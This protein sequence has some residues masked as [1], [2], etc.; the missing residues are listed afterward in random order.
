MW[1]SFALIVLAA[2]LVVIF[3]DEIVNVFKKYWKLS[4]FKLLVPLL[5]ASYFFLEFEIFLMWVINQFKLVWFNLANYIASFLPK[6]P[7]TTSMV[8]IALIF[9]FTIVPVISLDRWIVHRHK[10]KRLESRFY[11]SL[12][13]WIFMAGLYVSGVQFD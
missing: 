1:L 5:I 6:S 12:I 10:T 7:Q 11:T 4:W 13:I 2:T 9:L 3:A 8:E